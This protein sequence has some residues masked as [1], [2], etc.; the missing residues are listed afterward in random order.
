MYL[1]K[2]AFTHPNGIITITYKPLSSVLLVNG[3]WIIITD[4]ASALIKIFKKFF[5]LWLL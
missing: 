5:T 1:M 2:T 3:H 4:S